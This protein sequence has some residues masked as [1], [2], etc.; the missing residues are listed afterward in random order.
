MR[1]TLVDLGL[2][3]SESPAVAESSSEP[4]LLSP[5]TAAALLFFCFEV[6]S[7]AAF[8]APPPRRCL[9]AEGVFSSSVSEGALAAA[10][11]ALDPRLVGVSLSLESVS[12][13]ND[14][15][16]PP[17]TF[18]ELFVFN[19]S[20]LSSVSLMTAAFLGLFAC[21]PPLGVALGL[22]TSSLSVSL[23]TVP[24][25][26]VLVT[27]LA[28]AAVD[29]APFGVSLG[30]AFL[31]ALGVALG[32]ATSSLS[33]SLMTVPLEEVLVTDLALEAA[34][35]GVSFGVAFLAAV[36]LPR[37]DLLGVCSCD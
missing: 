26:D 33:V 6:D 9:P 8:D 27:D 22:T 7:A 19:N 2:S 14:L 25:E 29:A 37:G 5:L 21:L 36:A 35:F 34:P 10:A 4:A 11:A 1:L 16:L 13:T 12:L 32:L 24:L 31:A 20:S 28:L 17:P 23:M 15:C 3:A 30:V 18:L